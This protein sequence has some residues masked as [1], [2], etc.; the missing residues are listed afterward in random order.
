LFSANCDLEMAREVEVD[1]FVVPGLDLSSFIQ[2]LTGHKQQVTIG[3][4]LRKNDLQLLT[5]RGGRLRF[6]RNP[7]RVWIDSVQIR[8]QPIKGER[9]VGVV[10]NSRGNQI[11]VDIGT[12]DSAI[13]NV[14]AF[15]G[16]TK[17]NRPDIKVRPMQ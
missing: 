10:L 14:L 7:D 17:K 3:P 5:C 12:A 9:V 15:E 13:L 4:G 6:D 16:A 11:K 1:Q 2:N 8:Y